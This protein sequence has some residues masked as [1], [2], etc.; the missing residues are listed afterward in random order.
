MTMKKLLP[1]ILALALVFSLCACGAK[2]PT[3]ST[4]PVEPSKAPTSEA[5]AV[6][7]SVS[8]LNN[9]FFVTLTDGAK[10]KA[11]EM[12]VT[13]TVVDA[14]DDAAKQAND[15][16]DLI[17]K[18]IAVLI[19]NPVDSD[20]IAPAVKAAKAAGVKVIAVDRA[21]NGETVDCQIASDNV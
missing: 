2:T 4:P 20:A 21:V 5:V 1:L 10:A 19:V 18:K 17:A 3:T 7:M 12:N 16:D 11:T 15:I 13:L 9:P 14:G 8:T 6:G